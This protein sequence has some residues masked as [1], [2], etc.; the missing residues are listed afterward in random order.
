MSKTSAPSSAIEAARRMMEAFGYVVVGFPQDSD[1]PAIGWCLDEW[2]KNPL[3]VGTYLEV[4]EKTDR[5]DWTRQAKDLCLIRQVG[6]HPKQR[7]D[8]FFRCLLVEPQQ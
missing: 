3:P 6:A 7:G 2:A 1:M 5:A 8:K 4:K